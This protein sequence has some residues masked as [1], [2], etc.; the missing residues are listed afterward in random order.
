M[1]EIKEKCGQVC[2]TDLG[3][4]IDG[5]YYNQLWK[6]IDCKAMFKHSI[7]DRLSMF[8]KPVAKY[9]LPK[10]V[11]DEFTYQGKLQIQPLYADNSKCMSNVMSK[12]MHL[13]LQ[14]VLKCIFTFHSINLLWETTMDCR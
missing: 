12:S 6:N 5:K 1:E 13:R 9:N 11:K 3:S 7:F 10:Y 4:D 14:S 2:D 8:S